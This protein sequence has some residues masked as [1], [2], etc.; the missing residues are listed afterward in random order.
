MDYFESQLT[1]IYRDGKIDKPLRITSIKFISG[2]NPLGGGL[3]SNAKISVSG[4]CEKGKRSLLYP[5]MASTKYGKWT[6]TWFPAKKIDCTSG[7]FSYVTTTWEASGVHVVDMIS[8]NVSNEYF[9]K[10][11]YKFSR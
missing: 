4:I 11:G 5:E 8:G 7:K 1:S 6:G 3:Y 10:K 2:Q 9:F